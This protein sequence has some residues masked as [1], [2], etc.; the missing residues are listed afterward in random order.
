MRPPS[1]SRGRL[2]IVATLTIGLLAAACSSDPPDA[3]TPAT[4]TTTAASTATTGSTATT[5][6]PAAPATTATSAPATTAA[7]S[8]T[9]AALPPAT[10]QVLPGVD[11]VAVLRAT[12][13]QQLDLVADDGTVAATGTADTAGSF[14]WRTLE[15]GSTYTVRSTGDAPT[16]SNPV[17]V[18]DPSV[19]P[20]PTLYTSQ[21]LINGFQYITVRDGTTLSANVMLPGPA[22]KGPY[23]TVVEYSG[24]QPSDPAS[25]TFGQLFNALGFAY[26]GVNMR[27][28]GCSGGSYQFFE[29]AQLTDG[30][31]VIEA[32]AHQ[33]WVLDNKVGMVGISYPGISQLFV[34]S[35]VP[36]DLA[37]ISP[38]SVLDDSYRA[39]GEPGGILNT[40]FAAP[41]LSERQ[42]EAKPYGQAW[43]KARADAGDTVCADNQALRLQNPDFLAVTEAQDFYDPAQA[44]PLAPTTFVNKIDVPVFIAGAWQDEQTGGHFPDMLDKFT[45][46]P[47]LYA[48]LTNGLHTESLSP[49]IFARMVE[50]LD[51]YVAHETPSLDGAR[52]VA[53]ILVPQLYGVN[54]ATL[55]PDRFTGMSYEQAL[56]AF[57]S[58]PPIRAL[59]EEGDAGAEPGAPYPRFTSG[60]SAWPVPEAVATSWYLGDHGLLSTKP[61]TATSTT[62]PAGTDDGD[63]Y[64]ADP[65]LL[66]KAFYPG[67]RSS[68]IWKAGTTYD[69]EPLPAGSGVG[70]LTQRLQSDT[71]VVGGGSVDLW[72]K[73]TTPDTDLEVTIS[74]VR[75]DGTEMYIQSGWLRASH[76]KLDEAR[77]TAVLPVQTHLEAD[78]APLPSGQFTPVRIELFPFAYVFRKD[79]QIRITVD[80]PGD[81]RPVW[82][83]DTIDHGETVTIAHD[84]DHPSKI[85]LQVVPG[86]AAPA[87]A[88]PCGSLRGQPCRTYVPA[89]NESVPI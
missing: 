17:Q 44:D 61:P 71:T 31:D 58:D 12:P 14:L 36:P 10:F 38:L 85:V 16:A 70:Y 67:G 62:A 55:P 1:S 76:R 25:N 30:Y 39:T 77:S 29:Q 20:D 53:K 84:A 21:H 64:V 11:Q 50:F 28:T 34:A 56:A 88:A 82:A 80:A 87:G 6:A 69:W 40:G 41:F 32:V 24:Y 68:D 22:D 35:T 65:S 74:E 2:A 46:S 23:P 66:P 45:G 89:N 13:G 81:S 83:F 27:G 7:A 86:I 43:T 51:L 79:S 54:D 26:V 47:H 3:A 9:T 63:S 57:E 15:P 49:T 75:P 42:D 52:V 33:A 4:A 5:A 18:L 8:T 73:A 19:P 48:D 60:F 78:A 72:I 59:F 37:A